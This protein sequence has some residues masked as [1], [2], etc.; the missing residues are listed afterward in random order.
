MTA[1]RHA[2]PVDP[3][4][5][6][7]HLLTV[8]HNVREMRF[9]VQDQSR[10][11]NRLEHAMATVSELV[12]RLSAGIDRIEARIAAGDAT[13]AEVESLRQQL[14]DAQAA[15]A[16][17]AEQ[18]SQDAANA[19][20]PLVDRVDA[21]VPAPAPEPEPEPVEGEQPVEELPAA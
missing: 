18:A 3:G 21:I 7:D 6:L 4:E 8:D 14:A 10:K 5:L 9:A 16:V 19:F 1:G 15:T 20:E 2:V 12:D 13:E 17:A 11:I